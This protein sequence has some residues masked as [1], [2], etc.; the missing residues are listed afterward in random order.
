MSND[1]TPKGTGMGA[2]ALA[3]ELAAALNADLRTENAIGMLGQNTMEW[4]HQVAGVY[5]AKPE[6]LPDH[7][8]HVTEIAARLRLVAKLA[9]CPQAVPEN[10]HTAVGAIF[11]VLGNMRRAMERQERAGA[12]A[13]IRLAPH[14]HIGACI[15]EGRLHATVMHKAGNGPATVVAMAE[16]AV[17]SMKEHDCIAT[18]TPAAQN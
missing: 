12:D 14:L 3:G 10:D 1:Q 13:A 8:D 15:T 18:M 9:G 2:Q 6:P 4:L 17:D 7:A 5:L 11:S 16:M